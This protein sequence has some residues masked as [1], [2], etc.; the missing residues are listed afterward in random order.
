MLEIRYENTM[1]FSGHVFDMIRR[2]KEDRQNLKRIR[3]RSK[4]SSG[5]YH[6]SLPDI[7][8]EEFEKIQQQTK[9]KEGLEARRYFRGLLLFCL[10]ITVTSLLLL[11]FLFLR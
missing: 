7:S 2:N 4:E 5:K 11:G 1:S 6:S 10:L 8:A 9:E 3:E